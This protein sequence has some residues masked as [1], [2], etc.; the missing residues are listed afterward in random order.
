MRICTINSLPMTPSSIYQRQLILPGFG[1]EGQKKLAESLI[2][3]V[4]M[5]GLGTISAMYLVY[6]GAK[7]LLLVDYDTVQLENLHRQVLYTIEDVGKAKVQVARQKLK[8]ISP[9]VDIEIVN[10][11]LT[12]ENISKILNDA[13]LIIDGTDNLFSKYLLND[14]SYHTK[15]PLIYGAVTRYYGHISVFN[16]PGEQPFMINY[17]DIFPEITDNSGIMDCS[18]YGVLP[19]VV[20]IIGTW[21]ATEA[22][23]VITRCG[24]PLYGKLLVLEADVPRF[25]LVKLNPN[26]NNPLRINKELKY[27]AFPCAISKTFSIN[28]NDFHKIIQEKDN[29]Y[30]IIDIREK[31]E[32][33]NGVICDF[34]YPFSMLMKEPVST[35]ITKKK[36]IIYCAKGQRSKQAAAILANYFSDVEF[37]SLEG[38][39][40]HYSQC[41]PV[42]IKL[43]H[44]KPSS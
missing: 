15:K 37:Y 40:E 22:I 13:N 21:Q 23:K 39:F 43:I 8:H 25:F 27:P 14:Y 29:T 17:R 12:K 24:K 28:I 35:P 10:E 26:P 6:T 3:I 44:D 38:G 11:P 2:A 33:K 4:G 30:Q 41:F 34:N 16:V 7:K 32:L 5:G 20:G 36:V 1:Q 19:P 9:D 42:D 18:S 31:E